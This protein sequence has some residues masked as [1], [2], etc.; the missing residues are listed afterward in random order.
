LHFRRQFVFHLLTLLLLLLLL[1]YLVY[2][3]YLFVNYYHILPLLF[4]PHQR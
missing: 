4:Y 2:L 3:S 1:L